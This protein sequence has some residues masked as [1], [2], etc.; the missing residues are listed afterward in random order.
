MRRARWLWGLLLLLALGGL[1]WW[2]WPEV[3][4][5]AARQ[6]A[7]RAFERGD[8]ATGLR[9]MLRYARRFG[10]HARHH[11]PLRLGQPV[12]LSIAPQPLGLRVQLPVLPAAEAT[13]DGAAVAAEQRPGKFVGGPL[14][15]PG[16]QLVY[17]AQ[18]GEA[19]PQMVRLDPTTLQ[20]SISAVPLPRHFTL[21]FEAAAALLDHPQQAA[22]VALQPSFSGAGHPRLLALTSDGSWLLFRAEASTQP[23]L[24]I[25]RCR[26]DGSEAQRLGALENE[27]AAVAASPDGTQLACFDGPRVMLLKLADEAATV[28][29]SYPAAT[30]LQPAAPAWSPD[31]QELAYGVGQAGEWQVVIRR[32]RGG[33]APTELV[34][35]NPLDTLWHLGAGRLLQGQRILDQDHPLV[36]LRSSADSF[37]SWILADRATAPALDA[38]GL[39]LAARQGGDLLVYYLEQPLVALPLS[40]PPAAGKLP[41]RAGPA[42]A[43]PSPAPDNGAPKR[44]ARPM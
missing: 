14:W 36:T 29:H 9:R 44:P 38:T 6:R 16:G 4:P 43:P 2:A 22:I 7:W 28:V 35:L 18:L 3:S 24:E 23:P 20:R 39:R 11:D 26:P 1:G 31:G 32:L 25:W 13:S 37:E 8:E 41:E 17:T 27:P 34:R 12:R 19:L 40:A 30:V 15:L 42:P 33:A 10:N 21:T 5:G